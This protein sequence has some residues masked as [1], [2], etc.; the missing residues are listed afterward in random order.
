MHIGRHIQRIL[1][2]QGRMVTWLALQIPCDRTN[3]Y[4]IFKKS[5]IDTALLEKIS[6]ILNHNFFKDLSNELH[7]ADKAIKR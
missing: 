5:A 1:K 4:L 7:S 2:S 3:V 6:I